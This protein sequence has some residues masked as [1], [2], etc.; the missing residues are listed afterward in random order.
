MQRYP[1]LS[2]WFAAPLTERVGRLH[3]EGPYQAT[4]RV[5]YQGKAL[6]VFLALHGYIQLDCEWIIAIRNVQLEDHQ[7]ASMP[8][9][10]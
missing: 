4:C 1:D 2:D 8:M 3:G 7:S 10:A 5:S 6:P 9:L